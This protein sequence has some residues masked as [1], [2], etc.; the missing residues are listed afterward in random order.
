MKALKMLE[1]YSGDEDVERWIDRFELAV[2]IDELSSRE[3]Q[4]LAMLL[5]NEAYDVWKNLSA[6]D[7]KDPSAI[8]QALRKTFGLSR[9]VA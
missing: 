6:A 2:E 3:E 5:T 8:K 7:K 1:K 4:V 9:T